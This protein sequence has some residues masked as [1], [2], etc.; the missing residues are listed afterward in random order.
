L[1]PSNA[2][3]GVWGRPKEMATLSRNLVVVKRVRSTKKTCARFAPFQKRKG[4]GETHVVP[5]KMPD[6]TS[7]NKLG[8]GT[9][10]HLHLGVRAVGAGE[11]GI[12]GGV[13]ETAVTGIC[14]RVGQITPSTN[15]G[16]I[17]NLKYRQGKNTGLLKGAA[18]PQIPEK[19]SNPGEV[20]DGANSHS[21]WVEVKNI[22]I[23]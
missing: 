23:C 6:K 14:F 7:T 1:F 20:W 15:K 5:K 10:K 9:K 12:T 21:L 13:E 19:A 17:K 8:G 2:S 22:R 16:Y 18:M 11:K 3:K 4:A